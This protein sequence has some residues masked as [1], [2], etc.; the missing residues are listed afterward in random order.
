[1][2][3]ATMLLTLPLAL[4]VAGVSCE[5]LGAVAKVADATKSVLDAVCETR[6]DP[7]LDLAQQM[8]ANGD[9]LG[10]AKELRV[11]LEEH[12]HDREVSALLGLVE[13]Q[14]PEGALAPLFPSR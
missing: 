2:R 6:T 11:Y 3:F 10:A 14:L 7:H 1:M 9:F 8:Y 5:Q 13:S 12:G 4:F